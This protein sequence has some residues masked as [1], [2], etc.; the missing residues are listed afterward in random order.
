MDRP[1]TLRVEELLAKST[2]PPND[3]MGGRI[4]HAYLTRLHIRYP[5][6]DRKDLWRLHENRWR[7]AKAKREE[8]S[9]SERFGIFKLY[10]TYAIGATTMQL[11]EKYDYVPPE[12]GLSS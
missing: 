8:L 1:R 4:L 3:E 12:V 5:F 11:S 10:L 6:L 7:L 9:Q 2:E